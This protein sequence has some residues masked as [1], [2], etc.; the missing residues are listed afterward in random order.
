MD[1]TRKLE[2]M[3][4]THI[5]NVDSDPYIEN[6]MIG[7]TIRSCH[8]GIKGL[9]V[10]FTICP[11]ARLKKSHPNLMLEYEKYLDKLC[12]E[13]ISE[14]INCSVRE[15]NGDTLR[16]NW[17]KFIEECERPYMMFLEH[18]WKFDKQIN[19]SDVIQCFEN[20]SNIN[21]LRLSKFDITQGVVKNLAHGLNWDW[22]FEEVKPVDVI[23]VS[24]ISFFSG[25]P[26]FVRVS[27]YREKVLKWLEKYCPLNLSKGASHLEKDLKKVEMQQIDEFRNCGLSNERSGWY[28]N[29]EHWGH[30]WPLSDSSGIGK[31][32]PDCEQA[33]RRQ[34][35][36]WG[37]YMYGHVGESAIVSH[38]GDWCA[39][40]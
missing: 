4:P 28:K 9:D 14:G 2:V 29:G 6:E 31:G 19:I 18:D 24:K 30:L 27:F 17:I 23:P 33:I 10:K 37:N 34:H 8:W 16:G 3:V 20:N 40:K 11:D 13:L 26:H 36:L 22:M 35:E 38:L 1:M 12:K 21:Y 32:C 25:N 15:E 7:K 39:K 5:I